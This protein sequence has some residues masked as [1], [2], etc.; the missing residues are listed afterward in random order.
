MVRAPGIA[1]RFAAPGGA[2]PECRFANAPAKHAGYK[3]W[4]TTLVDTTYGL[5]SGYRPP[6]LVP[7]GLAGMPGNGMVRAMLVPDLRAMAHAARKAGAP[8]TVRSAYRS[9]ALQRAVFAGWVAVSGQSEA[10]RF[11]ARAGHSEHQLGTTLDLGAEGGLAPW[12]QHFSRT[13]QGHWI[14]TRAWKFGFVVSY[15]PGARIRTCYSAEA[16][17]VRYVGREEARAVH[18]SGLPLREWLWH[19]AGQPQ[20]AS[21]ARA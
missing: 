18:D 16:W 6:D 15:P 19:H 4:A 20:T 21:E 13:K 12:E 2:L 1:P 9:A 8:L 5:R 3:R 10:L 14:A 11:S 7:V 17:H